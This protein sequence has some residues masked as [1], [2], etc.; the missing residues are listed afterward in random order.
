MTGRLPALMTHLTLAAPV[1]TSA[2]IFLRLGIGGAN[3]LEGTVTAVISVVCTILM[4]PVLFA[5]NETI[6]RIRPGKD[7]VV[8]AAKRSNMSEA[9][10]LA[11]IGA[12]LRELRMD[13]RVSLHAIEE[14]FEIPSKLL[15]DFEHGRG[16]LPV[17][18]LMMVASAIESQ[19]MLIPARR[20]PDGSLIGVEI[21]ITETINRIPEEDDA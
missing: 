7:P 18:Y 21:S 19:V 12:S 11:R 1:V 9:V 10:S 14:S 4:L 2:A 16:D 15:D 20:L 13:K 8:E 5:I 3:T 6:A 17:S